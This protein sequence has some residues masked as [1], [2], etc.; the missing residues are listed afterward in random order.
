MPTPVG[1]SL[2]SLAIGAGYLLPRAPLG[3]QFQAA[4]R[5]AGLLAGAVVVGNLP[6]IDYLPGILEGYLNAYHHAY[7][8]SIGWAVLVGAGLWL[9]WR[10]RD[11]GVDGWAGLFL[12]AL[13][14][15]HLLADLVTADGLAPFGI[16]LGWPLDSGFW[17]SPWLLFPAVHKLTYAEVLQWHNVRVM[18]V[19]AAWTLPLVLLVL[20]WKTR[21]PARR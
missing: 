8:H 12:I 7:T 19:E 17:Y 2:I 4:R 18:A 16:M 20:L 13:L 10:A 5:R 3:V 1:H 15:A 11:P 6:D 9:L 21:G 14:V